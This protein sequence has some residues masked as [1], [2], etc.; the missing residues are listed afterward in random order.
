[1]IAYGHRKKG[2][3]SDIELVF[4]AGTLVTKAV[5][6]EGGEEAKKGLSWTLYSQ[7]N[8]EGERKQ[9]THTYDKNANFKVPAGNYL[10]ALKR[11]SAVVKKEEQV[12]AGETT[13]VTLSLQAGIW[14]CWRCN[15]ELF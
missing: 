15:S 9:V 4:G 10:L 6:V 14:Q 11:G 7:P 12:A 3:C 2:D 8:S 13:E 5:M 1:M